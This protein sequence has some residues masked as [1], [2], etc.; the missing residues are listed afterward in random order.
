[1]ATYLTT[2]ID[3]GQTFS[4]QVYMPT[5][6]TPPLTRSQ[7][8][9][10]VLGPKPDNV[11]VGQQQPGQH[12]RLRHPDGAG[13]L[14]WPGLPDLGR[15]LQPGHLVVNNVVQGPPLS[16][17]FQKMVIAAGPRIVTSDVGPIPLAECSQCARSTLPSLSTGRSIR[18]ASMKVTPPPPPLPP[19]TSWSTI[20]D[21]QC[22]DPS[23]PLRV[24]SVNPVVASGMGP[25][26][27]FGYTQLT[28][29][30]FRSPKKLPGG[31]PPAASPTTP[32]RIGLHD[33]AG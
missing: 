17:E 18:R 19:P 5:R 9:Q 25:D 28:G 3:G 8:Q 23:V 21:H 4:P 27:R 15:Q 16:I 12:L 22:C 33:P 31:L 20:D 32:G 30:A 29:A 24:E 14:Q 11:V 1:M 10:E 6:R 2:S 13:C 26:N 7:A